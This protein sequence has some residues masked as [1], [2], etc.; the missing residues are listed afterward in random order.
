MDAANH[1]PIELFI[2]SFGGDEYEMWALYDVLHHSI[3]SP[4]HT[5][6]IGKCMS[7]APLLVASGTL[8]HRYAT[9]NAWFMVHEGSKDYYADRPES[10]AA[11]L[12]HSKDMDDRWFLAMEQHT[13]KPKQFWKRNCIGKVEDIYFSAIRAQEWGIIDYIWDEA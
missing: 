5:I 11:E 6:A 13:N 4:I 12:K 7:A 9:P 8:G 3:S 1:K 10:I 2:G